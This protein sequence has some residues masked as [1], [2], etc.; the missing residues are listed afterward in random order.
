MADQIKGWYIANDHKIKA[1][2]I[3]FFRRDGSHLSNICN[4]IY[5]NKKQVT[6]EHFYEGCDNQYPPLD[7]IP[8]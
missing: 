5:L 7:P 6:M 1:I 2:E 3:E 8:V 4:S